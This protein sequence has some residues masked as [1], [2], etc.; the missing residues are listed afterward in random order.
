MTIS[1]EEERISKRVEWCLQKLR[2]ENA[3]GE[4]EIRG[5]Q[6]VWGQSK[7]CKRVEIRKNRGLL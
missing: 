6:E 4:S 7:E 5:G 3:C 1:K 2:G